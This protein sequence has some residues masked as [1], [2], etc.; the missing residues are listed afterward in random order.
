VTPP[1]IPPTKPAEAGLIPKL[2]FPY[3]STSELVKINTAP[4]VVASIHAYENKDDHQN[5][6]LVIAWSF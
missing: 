2:V 1:A 5:R 4:L 3:F 6:F